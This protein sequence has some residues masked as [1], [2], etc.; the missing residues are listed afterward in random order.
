MIRNKRNLVCLERQGMCPLSRGIKTSLGYFWSPVLAEARQAFGKTQGFYS[1]MPSQSYPRTGQCPR[2]SELPVSCLIIWHMKPGPGENLVLQG[3]CHGPSDTQHTLPKSSY[4]AILVP[5][6]H[7]YFFFSPSLIHSA[8]IYWA[9]TRLKAGL[10]LWIERRIWPSSRP[11]RLFS[12]VLTCKQTPT[13]EKV[14]S[15]GSSIYNWCGAGRGHS[16]WNCQ[17]KSSCEFIHCLTP[18]QLTHSYTN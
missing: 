6:K 11:S 1:T 3:G 13:M 17:R 12:L 7:T 5:Q 8:I 2:Q 9:P 4:P 18:R 15:S 10:G 14:G 16:P